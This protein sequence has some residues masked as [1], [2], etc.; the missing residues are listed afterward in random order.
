MKKSFLPFE[1]AREYAQSLNLSGQKEWFRDGNRP[2]NI[3]SRPYIN[4]KENW[5]SWGDFLGT[6]NIAPKLRNFLPFEE[7]REYVR[8]L[9]L[10]TQKEWLLFEKPKNIPNNPESTYKNKGWLNLGDWLGT[11]R[12]TNAAKEFLSFE[13]AKQYAFSSGMSS[14]KDWRSRTHPS[15]IPTNPNIFYKEKG[16]LSWGSWFGTDNVAVKRKTFLT[17]KEARR[18]AR[19]LKLKN[20]MD[21][22]YLK[23]EERDILGLPYNPSVYYKKEWVSWGDFLGSPSKVRPV[24]GQRFLYF[25]RIGEGV[26]GYGVTYEF[27]QRNIAHKKN[28]KRAGLELKFLLCIEFKKGENARNIEKHFKRNYPVLPLGVS[29]FNTENT[30]ME[31]YPEMLQMALE[32]QKGDR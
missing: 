12:V 7:A 11:Y 1:E 22:F 26:L 29:G 15:N 28:V 23:E 13:E 8:S 31:F 32:M 17:F 24:N 2:E 21:W 10:K 9:G 4:Y 6:G 25:Y 14:C 3:P 5:V 19:G 20:S 18:S 27:K 30:S 16:W